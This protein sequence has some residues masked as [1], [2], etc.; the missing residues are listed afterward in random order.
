MFSNFTVHNTVK[1]IFGKG[2]I[3]KLSD[4]IK[5]YKKIML[6]YGGGSIMQNGVYDQVKAA[7]GDK[8]VVE[9]GGIE[10]NPTYET[11]MKGVEIARAEKVDFLLAVGGGSV[12]D[13]TKFMS[14][15]IPYT[16]N[17][18]WN[19]IVIPRSKF[20]E[21]TPLGAVLTLPATGSEMNYYAVISRKETK[22]K[23]GMGGPLLYP[24]FSILDPE[25]T[26][27]LPKRQIANGLADAFTHV[28][29]QYLTYPVGAMIQDG[30]A[31][32]ILRTLIAVAPTTLEN[33]TDY[34]ARANFMWAATVAL[35]GTI[36]NGVPTDW[37]THQIGHELTA[38]HG[39]DHARSLAVV[40][41]YLFRLK[42][43]K[44][45]P[46]LIQYAKNVWNL[47]GTDEELVDQAI[48]KTIEFYESIGIPTKASD[49]G[50]NE[51]SIA[52]VSKRIG[53][54]GMKFGENADIGAEETR[55]ILE[56]SIV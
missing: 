46:K 30:F 31:E 53:E 38:L 55:A 42:K 27:S 35:N 19:D 47:T 36:N 37:A 48:A 28:M 9:F 54:R 26:Y 5:G 41:P 39:I 11:L 15:A 56:M 12:V 49:Y 7:L 2:S 29:E 44:K 34:E 3:A 4:N 10:A 8:N 22:Q 23:M 6:T 24:Q 33:P 16:G 50:V 43:D 14:A 18:A 13:G 21:V 17:D 20:T 1:L 40:M 32:T 52:E 25:T 45:G 51:E